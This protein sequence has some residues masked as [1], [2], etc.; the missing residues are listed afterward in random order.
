MSEFFFY[1]LFFLILSLVVIDFLTKSRARVGVQFYG[2]FVILII[3]AVGRSVGF[4][5][6]DQ[7]YVEI[8]KKI[9]D[10]GFLGAL[11]GYE[12]SKYNV[13][14]GFFLLL[15]IF[16]LIGNSHFVVFGGVSLLAVYFNLR[17]IRAFTPYFV[18]SVLVYFS[19]FYIAKELN[20]IRA[21]LSSALLFYA[22]L[23]ILRRQWLR[24]FFVWLAA[25]LIHVSAAIFALPVILYA[26]KPSRRN[27]IFLALFIFY[28][29]FLFS[30]KE[31]ALYLASFG[32]VG[33]KLIL[34]L[35]ADEYSYGIPLIN[36]VNLK[37]VSILI[38]AF[39]LWSK[40]VSRY[41][42]FYLSFVFFYSASLF[43]V[44]F[45]DFA[46]LAGRGYSVLS[47]FEFVLVP[48]IFVELLGRRLGLALAATYALLTLWMNF[49]VNVAWSGGVEFFHDWHRLW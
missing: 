12:Y 26:M 20:A 30:A 3:V 45:G 17:A 18:V 15:A 42:G 35:N 13:E 10:E 38:L 44:L 16:S 24:S 11:E 2:V 32:F 47:M 40:L 37:N 34:Y 33:E 28:F 9:S 25:I 46:I 7:A 39:V 23:A 22:A 36:I 21:G 41:S 8:Y 27:L 14:F 19:H 6:D 49:N 1:F 43:R 4:G 48:I 29:S 31:L 5:S